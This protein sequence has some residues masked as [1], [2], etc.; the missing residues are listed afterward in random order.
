MLRVI[1]RLAW[2]NLRARA[3]EALLLLFALCLSTTVLTLALAVNQTGNGAWD[4]LFQATH[5]PDVMVSAGYL[6]DTPDP[7]LTWA[8]DR[9]AAIAAAPGVVAVRWRDGVSASGEVGGVSLN[10]DVEI[11]DPAPDSVDQPLVT[12]GQWL[13]GGDGV[14]LEDA[15]ASILHVQPGD[16]VTIA[17]L[18]LPVRGSAMAVTAFRYQPGKGATV[19]ISRAVAARLTAAGVAGDRVL[20]IHLRLADP[21]A[22]QRF[23]EAHSTVASIPGQIEETLPDNRFLELDTWQLLRDHR[24]DDL[25]ALGIALGVIGTLLAGLAVA[26]AA[27]L[28]AGRMAAQTRLVGTLKAVG[29]TPRQV[30]GVLL[31]EYLALAGIATAVG[32]V[33]GTFLA[34]LLA[35]AER[36]LYGAPEAPPITLARLGIVAAVGVAVVVLATLRPAVRGIRHSTVRSLAADVRPARRAG[37]LARLGEVLRLPPVAA[38]GLRSALRRPARTLIHTARLTLAVAMLIIG[39]RLNGGLRGMRT[40]LIRV[41]GQ[42]P[43]AHAAQEALVTRILVLGVVASAVLMGLAAVNT[44]IIA[45]YAARD[46]ARN[47][48][49]IRTLGATPRQTATSFVIAQLGAA[50]LATA[51]GIPLGVIMFGV[52]DPTLAAAGL[53]PATYLLVALA[54]PV[55]YAGIVTIPARTLAA[56]PITPLLTYE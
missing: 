43:A 50:L 54:I 42:D 11:R 47:H 24:H 7:N 19:W 9:L 2:R 32:L 21:G 38:I 55:V 52:L 6:P 28:V 51:V 44:V 25:D 40:G 17:G 8:R 30:V 39:L 12:G 29:V 13:D 56:R 26:T 14:V 37:R 48:A 20:G 16:T 4:R 36:T 18:R 27:V 3:G 34:P 5:G 31:A 10:L 33:A 49:I 41:A 1:G 46:T 53:S 23:I 22:A 15:L 45:V 35:S